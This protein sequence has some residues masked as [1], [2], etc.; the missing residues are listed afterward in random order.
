MTID[1]YSECPI[2]P[3]VPEAANALF[4]KS[5]STGISDGTHPNEAGH[6]LIA[7]YVAG[8]LNRIL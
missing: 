7:K 3:L 8:E 1:L 2:N 4:N 6:M 5:S